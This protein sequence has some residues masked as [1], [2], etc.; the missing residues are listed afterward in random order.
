MRLF[1]YVEGLF[2]GVISI[3]GHWPLGVDEKFTDFL[4]I[5]PLARYAIDLKLMMKV[6]CSDKSCTELKL[7]KE[8]PTKLKGFKPNHFFWAYCRWT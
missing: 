3:K 8:V 6:M 4:V 5:G 1:C 2:L 7:T